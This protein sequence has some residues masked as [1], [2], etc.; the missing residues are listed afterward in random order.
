MSTRIIDQINALI[1]INKTSEEYEAIFGKDIYA[2]NIPIVQSSDYNSGAIA[3]ELEFLRGYINF[4]IDSL[5]INF[6]ADEFLEKLAY[7]FLGLQRIFDEEDDDLKNRFDALI[8][9][10]GNKSWMTKWCLKDVFGYY[11][12]KDDIYIIENYIE[13]NLLLNSDFEI[14]SG[15]VFTNWNKTET[16]SSIIVN[17][18]DAWWL[19]VSNP[20]NYSSINGIENDNSSFW[21]AVADLGK[22]ATSTDGV[23]WILQIS[24]TT[25][26]LKAIGYNGHSMWVAVGMINTCIT[27][28]D[29]ET[30]TA[31]SIPGFLNHFSIDHNK[32]IG[33]E[34]LWVMGSSSGKINYS[35]DSINWTQVSTVFG[36]SGIY[37]VGYNGTDLWVAVGSRGKLITSVDGKVWSSL[38]TTPTEDDLYAVAHNQLTGGSALWVVVGYN[39]ILITSPDG[40][41]WTQR[42]STFGTDI[43]SDIVY[44]SIDGKW[45]DVGKDGQIATSTDGMTGWTQLESPFGT[46][47]IY[48]ISSGIERVKAV[49]Q[50]GKIGDARRMLGFSGLR[51]P[52]YQIDSSNS[53]ASLDQTISSVVAGDYKISF[54]YEDNEL[55]PDDNLIYFQVQRSGDSYYYNFSDNTW[56]SGSTGKYFETVGL[57]YVYAGVYLSNADTRDLTFTLSNAGASGTAY[58]FRIDLLKFGIWQLY[59]SIKVLIKVVGSFGGGYLSTW[60]GDEDSLMDNSECESTTSPML[61]NETTPYEPIPGS[62]TWARDTDP[63]MGTYSWKLNKDT[64][65]AGGDAETFLTDDKATSN[66]HGLVAG[67][68]YVF[69]CRAKADEVTNEHKIIIHEY[70][71]SAWNTT[72]ILVQ[73][74]SAYE[75]LKIV[76]TM[77]AATTGFAISVFIESAAVLNSEIQIDNIRIVEA[78]ADQDI[79]Q[80]SFYSSDYIAGPGG[81]YV[82]TVYSDLLELVKTAGVKGIVEI[83]SG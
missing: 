10:N 74:A 67:T 39:G 16:G 31:R 73:A 60:P 51:A 18:V 9:R 32:K 78:S 79:E 55:C 13:T 45:I 53:N 76:W 43:I 77:N 3:N 28:T 64:A 38:K 7:F 34:G 81:G 71:S 62:Q 83:I 19:Q 80:A 50:T 75:R 63:Y 59:P 72:E 11:F 58:K 52:E 37:S 65:A 5:N 47:D 15:D 8:L 56:Q 44:D 12:D 21:I 26:Q 46:S 17:V 57:G 70:Y 4:V 82:S 40:S 1:P 68:D 22:I 20:F 42:T 33:T 25:Q 29:G 2:S 35:S 23:E 27:S 36:I 14:G 41:T 66:M 61:F 24:G 30:W 49:S 6:A 54:F 48:G 69:E